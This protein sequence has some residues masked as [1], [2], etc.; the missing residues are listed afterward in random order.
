MVVGV[1]VAVVVV[2]VVA[3]VVK[4][5]GEGGL[6]K[7]LKISAPGAP[8]YWKNGAG[9]VFLI[10]KGNIGHFEYLHVIS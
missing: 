4:G 3:V 9:H 7:I 1:V 6:H 5:G 2:A 10:F 8:K